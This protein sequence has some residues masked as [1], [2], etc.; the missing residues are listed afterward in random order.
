MLRIAGL[1]LDI[2]IGEPALNISRAAEIIRKT[3]NPVDLFVLPE[4][5]TTGYSPKIFAQLDKFAEVKRGPSFEILSEVAKEKDCFI[6]YGFPEI[7]KEKYY[8]SQVIINNQGKLEGIYRKINLAQF[9]NA[10][11]KNYFT[12]GDW[13]FNFKIK[14]TKIALATCY[15]FRFPE[16]IKAITSNADLLLHPSTFQKDNTF[17]SWHPFVIT[18]AME[19]QVYVLSLNRAGPDFGSSIFCPPWVDDNNIPTVL[20][21][22][23]GI[24]YG[25]VDKNLIRK[26]WP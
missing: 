18:R 1:Q 23:E 20:G 3:L 11:E 24:L 17:S 9:G 14:E 2:E 4:L 12:E 21:S 10:V 19:N 13:G 8:I 26:D 6:S 15:D 16:F 25:T 22:K 7:S 5:Y